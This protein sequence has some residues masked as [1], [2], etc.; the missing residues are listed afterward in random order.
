MIRFLRR[1]LLVLSVALLPLVLAYVAFPT[2]AAWLAAREAAALG[3]ETLD[4]RLERPGLQGLR[5]RSLHA[6]AAGYRLD[7][8]DGRLSWTLAS[9]GRGRLVRIDV[10]SASLTVPATR[11]EPIA[12]IERAPAEANPG[13]SLFALLPFDAARVDVLSVALPALQ[14][15]ARGTLD[16]EA[17]RLA[18]R[19][20]GLAPARA[21]GLL[22]DARLSGSGGI[23][24]DLQQAA[25]DELPFLTV[26]S[27]LPQTRLEL[28]LEA[29]LTG[30]ALDLVAALAGLPAG[31]GL[32]SGRWQLSLPWP[33][34]A[35]SWPALTGNGPVRADWRSADG[36]F[37]VTGVDGKM[38]VSGGALEVD[39]A[40]VA[41]GRYDGTRVVLTPT[42]MRLVADPLSIDTRGDV[43]IVRDDM[44]LAGSG[45]AVISTAAGHGF[46][47]EGSLDGALIWNERRF[48]LRLQASGIL[49]GAEL[50]SRVQITSGS[51]RDVPLDVRGDLR[52]QRAEIHVDHPMAF[53]EPLLAGFWPGW[54]E[55]YD[56]DAG[57]LHVKAHFV[58]GAAGHLSGGGTIG[59][60]RVAAHV[61]PAALRGLSGTLDIVLDED[62]PRLAPSE[63]RASLV[64]FGVPMRDVEL[65]LS[66]DASVLTV[67]A[68]EL[69]LLGGGAVAAPF[70]YR[71]ADGVGQ[72]EVALADLDLGML[73]ALEGE[74]ITGTGRL[75][76]TLPIAFAG[77]GVRVVGGRLAARSPGGEIRLQP[78]I[79]RAITQPGLDVAL[80]ALT[81]FR[82]TL[83]EAIVDYS[84]Q[85]DL[86]LGVRL[87]G[88]NPDVEGGRPIH[89]N[90]NVSE[91]IPVLLRSL[92]LKDEFAERI[93]RKVQR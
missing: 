47:L 31:S 79:A 78:S 48:P 82:Y 87:Q 51:L 65:A 55:H 8:E 39:L 59:L 25:G 42:R 75:D 19:L 86:A 45:S 52:Q 13:A 16:Y 54:Q 24:L 89:F 11:S 17:D 27:S 69:R 23:E 60:A 85:G 43:Q 22:L 38:T 34:D 49:D 2:L 36:K 14:A 53:S 57:T 66:G 71:L 28:S 64:D 77:G 21:E 74:H 18:V 84:E 76:G 93:E 41:E 29:R 92:R 12:G 46:D 80:S 5:V 7:L 4:L 56:L 73:L 67:R 83:L 63:L 40:G 33:L 6:A 20:V 81:D 35:A 32:V 90:L 3:F 62:E 58:A 72:T 68:A 10:A 61:G 26:R 37:S 50:T 1:V 30:F 9:L 70:T 15:R 44:R 91:N 88:R